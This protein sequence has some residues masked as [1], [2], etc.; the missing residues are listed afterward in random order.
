MALSKYERWLKS[1]GDTFQSTLYEKI[2]RELMT[3]G[4]S[5]GFRLLV[6]YTAVESIDVVPMLT[7]DR[8]QTKQ[9]VGR[10]M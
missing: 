7:D 4:E 6:C 9:E 5:F 2:V 8:Q 10:Y 3:L 1:E